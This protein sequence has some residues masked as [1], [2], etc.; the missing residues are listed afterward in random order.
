PWAWTRWAEPTTDKPNSKRP[1]LCARPFSS[2]V[3]GPL[4]SPR[5]SRRIFIHMDHH[6][7]LRMSA[8]LRR[9]C[10]LVALVAVSA[11][12]RRA[13]AQQQ[14][15]DLTLHLQLGR[16]TQIVIP[17]SRGFMVNPIVEQHGSAIVVD[18]VEARVKI[19]EQTASTT[20]EI[21]LRNPGAQ[22]TEAIVLVPVPDGAVV[23]AFSFEGTASEPTM[24]ILS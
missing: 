21:N 23:N 20:M 11:G 16:A 2:F 7:S 5:V 14:D 22:Q 13:A 17:Q 6:R 8:L 3:T 1:R 24:Q 10:F 19:L 4:P 15:I 12:N 9:A 18:S